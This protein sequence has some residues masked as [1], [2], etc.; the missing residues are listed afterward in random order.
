MAAARGLRLLVAVMVAV[1]VGLVPAVAQAQPVFGSLT[2]LGS[3]NNCIE[4]TGSGSSDCQTQAPGL[5][6]SQDVVVSPDGTDVYVASYNDDAITEFARNAHGSL[7]EI[8]CIA[9]SSASGSTCSNRAATGLINPEAIAI[10]ADGKNVY[11]AA[12]DADS[13]ATSPSSPATPMA[14]SRRSPATTVSP[15]AGTTC[16]PSRTVTASICRTRW[17]SAQTGRTCTSRIGMMTRSLR[18]RATPATAP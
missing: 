17:R 16:V 11:V 15:R 10:S 5:S 1:T 3:P 6:G 2:Q 8:G 4:V 18:S 9:D 12:N 14:R 7:G 13:G